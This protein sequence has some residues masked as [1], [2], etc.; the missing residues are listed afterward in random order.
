MDMGELF[1]QKMQMSEHVAALNQQMATME[2][3]FTNPMFFDIK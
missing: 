3:D 2:T 1:K